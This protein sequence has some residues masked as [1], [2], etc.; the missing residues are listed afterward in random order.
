MAFDP[1]L[2]KELGRQEFDYSLIADALTRS[3]YAAPAK[4]IHDLMKAGILIGVK[5]GLYSVAPD[6]AHGPVCKETLANL[7]YGPSCIS[8]EYALAHHGLIPER[9]EVVTSVTTKRDKRFETP[10]GVF[11]Y[12]YLAKEKYREGISLVWMDPQ[13]PVL[14]ASPEK[15]LCDYVAFNKI[16]HLKN[17]EDAREFLLEDLRIDP[18]RLKDLDLVVLHRLNRSYKS[19]S[20]DKILAFLEGMHP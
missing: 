9:T 16:A 20:L 11:T 19:K 3:G 12:R 13:H 18:E 8:L 14:M 4:K 15:A 5:K 17:R 7:I 2:Y 1:L 6:Y 10:L